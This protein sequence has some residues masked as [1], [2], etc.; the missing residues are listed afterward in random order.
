MRDA[1]RST[2][3]R[4]LRLE[5]KAG[6]WSRFLSPR[7]WRLLRGSIRFDF[8]RKGGLERAKKRVIGGRKGGLITS[9][10][11]RSEPSSVLL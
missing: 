6:G 10:P 9:S 5:G 2:R 3:I 4:E 7:M 11:P 1:S 8:A